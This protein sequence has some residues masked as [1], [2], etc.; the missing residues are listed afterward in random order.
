M[1][2]YFIFGVIAVLIA[3]LNN[4]DK[5]NVLLFLSF[6]TIFIFTAFRTNYGN[7]FEA[8]QL[9][10]ENIKTGSD[11]YTI[12]NTRIEIGWILINKLFSH[13]GFNALI[14]FLSFVTCVIYYLFIVK[15]VDR[16][17]YWFSV[18]IYYFNSSYML[19]QLSAMRQTIA[20]VLFLLSLGFLI[21]KKYLISAL[22]ITM[23]VF[24]HTSALFLI[25][26]MLIFI[27]FK[28]NR[29]NKTAIVVLTSLLLLLFLGGMYLEPTMNTIASKLFKDQYY[30][31]LVQDEDMGRSNMSNII[32]Y[33]LL[34]IVLLLYYNKI[35]YKSM[36]LLT[37]LVVFGIFMLPLGYILSQASRLAF[38][39]LPITIVVYPYYMQNISN[40]VI[41][42]LFV[43]G[44]FMVF[45]VRLITFFTSEI[46]SP[47]FYE[48]H[49]ILNQIT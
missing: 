31:Y 10:F 25:L 8:Y 42:I 23:A 28:I 9:M 1:I 26:V 30:M 19:I 17:Y 32:I 43:S 18:L 33:S 3:Y 38:Y 20:I 40:K 49:S 39:F 37:I 5:R 7:D 34:L 11:E 4:F 48:Y 22:L 16:K 29:I 12:G 35:E 36:K 41:K 6:F 44:V 14:A 46:Y 45:V 47:Y 15:F 24:F 27:I 13:V 21:D 2:T